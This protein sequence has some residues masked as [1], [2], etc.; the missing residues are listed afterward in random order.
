[1]DGVSKEIIIPIE[2]DWDYNGHSQSIELYED[3][4][5]KEVIGIGYDFEVD[6]FPHDVDPVTKKTEINYEFY[7]YSGGSLTDINNWS[8]SYIP[9]GLT[10]KDIYYFS[11]D[12][13]KSFFKLDFYD[14]VDDKRQTNYTSCL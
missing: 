3:E 5:I 13:T 4:V 6:R 1:M 11:N 7:F 14:N 10:V 9:E 2:L 12:F 8:N